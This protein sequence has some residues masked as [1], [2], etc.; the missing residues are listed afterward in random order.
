MKDQAPSPAPVGYLASLVERVTPTEPTLRR[1]QPALFEG[2]HAALAEPA[3]DLADTHVARQDMAP[4][5]A[6]P[7][8]NLRP[9][10]APPAPMLAPRGSTPR[11]EQDHAPITAPQSVAVP[12]EAPHVDSTVR[13]VMV[14]SPVRAAPLPP[15]F[16]PAATT[17][18]PASPPEPPARPEAMRTRPAPAPE[19]EAAPRSRRPPEPPAEAPM[20]HNR[21]EARA[22]PVAIL[23]QPQPSAAPPVPAATPPRPAPLPTVSP[24][25]AARRQAATAPQPAPRATAR[26]L[27]PIE[28]T[29]GRIEVRAVTGASSASRGTS[30]A[31]PKLSLDQ[32]LRDRGGQR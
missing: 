28:V 18:A 2:T 9:M 16:A 19:R 25:N 29:I 8:T 5:L 30:T 20:T 1:R 11:T 21:A 23:T 10:D 3:P 13:V 32:Y 7:A 31:A 12:H 17:R 27:P 4:T 26:E 22:A 15:V 6:G 14:E 24:R